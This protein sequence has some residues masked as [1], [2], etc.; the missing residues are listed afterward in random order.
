MQQLSL[1]QTYVCLQLQ[2]TSLSTGHYVPQLADVIV[3]GNKKASEENHIN[4]KGILVRS[5]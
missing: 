2:H 1:V 5:V 3:E 4:F